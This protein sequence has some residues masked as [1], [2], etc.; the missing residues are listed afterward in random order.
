MQTQATFSGGELASLY[1]TM[2]MAKQNLE[3][4]GGNTNLARDIGSFINMLDRASFEGEFSE[5]LLAAA[6][7]VYA[8]II[9]ERKG[10]VQYHPIGKAPYGQPVQVI[11]PRN[12]TIQGP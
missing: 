6:N 8:R 11:T 2:M 10:D 5:P 1:G 3:R 7:R 4:N 9:E 12:P